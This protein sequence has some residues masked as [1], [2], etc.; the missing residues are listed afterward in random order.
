MPLADQ[1]L[2]H[3]GASYQKVVAPNRRVIG[4]VTEPGQTQIDERALHRS[5]LWRFLYFLG[6]QTAALQAG[7]QLLAEQDQGSAL[8]RFLGAVAPHKHRSEARGESL[9]TARRLL[10]LIDRWNRTFC[11][12]FFPRFATRP[13]SP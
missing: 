8:H 5:T 11:Q 3:D 13:R 10:H 12:S 1:Y 2:E 7:L 9:R 6:A 4:Y